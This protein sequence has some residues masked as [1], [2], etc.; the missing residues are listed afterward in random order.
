MIKDFIGAASPWI[1]MGV[2][3]AVICAFKSKKER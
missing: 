1:V 2:F 3:V